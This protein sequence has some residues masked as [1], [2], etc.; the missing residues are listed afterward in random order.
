[1]CAKNHKVHKLISSRVMVSGWVP[2]LEKKSLLFWISHTAFIPHTADN[3]SAINY[4]MPSE[5]LTA[6]V[7]V[8]EKNS[9]ISSTNFLLSNKV[10][11]HTVMPHQPGHPTCQKQ[12]YRSVNY[13]EQDSQNI[14][15]YCN[16]LGIH[17]NATA[18]QFPPIS[19]HS[20]SPTPK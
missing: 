4:F 20:K 13:S 8:K 5:P 14:Y 15:P 16:V 12:T 3:K 11:L 7:M 2:P 17:F 10:Y 9:V 1:M 6:S 19:F 18:L